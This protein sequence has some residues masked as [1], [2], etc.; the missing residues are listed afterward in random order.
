MAPVLDAPKKDRFVNNS[1][2][3]LGVVVRDPGGKGGFKGIPMY[4]GH[5]VDLDE[6]EQAMTANAPRDPRANPLANGQLKVIAEGMDF[7]GRR[8][9]R[10]DPNIATADPTRPETWS[11]EQQQ[12]MTVPETAEQ[13]REMEQ[14]QAETGIPV[15]P[16]QQPAVGEYDPFE[17]H[18]QP[19]SQPAVVPGAMIGGE[20][21]TPETGEPAV[22][23]A[24]DELVTS[25]WDLSEP[26]PD[27]TETSPRTD[28]VVLGPA[29]RVG[30][31]P[32][33]AP[34]A[35]P[36]QL[37]GTNRGPRPK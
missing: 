28:S 18:G 25:A 3:I 31:A 36:G 34:K 35:K 12:H 20:V 2:G 23:K 21:A 27:E 13:M 15:D 8:P 10:P 4:P 17:E 30:H 14:A 29:D 33:T 7:K 6:E 19:T 1:G 22:Q 26:V 5:T 37:Q 9:L 32:S 11:T 24:P 16:S